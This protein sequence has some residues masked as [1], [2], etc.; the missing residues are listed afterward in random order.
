MKCLSPL[1]SLP[2]ESSIQYIIILDIPIWVQLKF[3]ISTFL[4]G[5]MKECGRSHFDICTCHYLYETSVPQSDGVFIIQ[6]TVSPIYHY[7]LRVKIILLI[8][9]H[10]SSVNMVVMP[11]L[12]YIY[13]WEILGRKYF[14]NILRT[15]SL[16]KFTIIVS[17]IY[18][19]T[20]HWKIFLITSWHLQQYLPRPI[21]KY[22]LYFHQ[23]W[24]LY[25][26][27]KTFF[28]YIFRFL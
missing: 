7:F 27:V 26:T 21:E 18:I 1:P 22:L 10:I 12:F 9:M 6:S 3:Y 4:N 16:I 20:Q 19:Y 23:S 8:G 17:Y 11:L 14:L 25:K 5:M 2:T 24:N 28:F 15:F 13:I